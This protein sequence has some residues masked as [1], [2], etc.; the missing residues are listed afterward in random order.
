MW[1]VAPQIPTS[2]REFLDDKGIEYTEIH[3]AEFRRVAERHA[4]LIQSETAAT[5]TKAGGPISWAAWKPF[6][7]IAESKTDSFCHYRA[8]GPR[9]D[10]PSLL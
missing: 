10:R 8:H 5:Q 4:F 9:C 2:V 7:R 3:F 1:L 6:S